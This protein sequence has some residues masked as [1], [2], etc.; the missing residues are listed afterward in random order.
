MRIIEQ[1]YKVERVN[2]S[3]LAFPSIPFIEHK[4][5]VLILSNILHFFLLETTIESIHNINKHLAPEALIFINVHSKEHYLNNNDYNDNPGRTFKH[6]FS[7]DD[8]FTL[9]P[10]TEFELLYYADVYAQNDD[11]YIQFLNEWIRQLCL[12]AKVTDL[13]SIQYNQDKYLKDSNQSFLSAIFK[14]KN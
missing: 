14:K 9:Y 11:Y 5:N 1:G 4:F 13:K 6:F 12:E 3:T 8:L 10:A 2:Y 7:K